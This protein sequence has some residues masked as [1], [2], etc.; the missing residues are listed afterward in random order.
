MIIFTEL[1]DTYFFYFCSAIMS[2]ISAALEGEIDKIKELI[3]EGADVNEADEDGLTSIHIAAKNVSVDYYSGHR[4]NSQIWFLIKNL[5]PCPRVQL[6]L[7]LFQGTLKG[8]TPRSALNTRIYIYTVLITL[9]QLILQFRS[10]N[11]VVCSYKVFKLTKSIWNMRYLSLKD[12]KL[13]W[14]KVI[15]FE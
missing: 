6:A 8:G 10:Y 9:I 14:I 4:N 13:P 12:E 5:K 1:D 2:L 7:P 15:R 11:S 3:A